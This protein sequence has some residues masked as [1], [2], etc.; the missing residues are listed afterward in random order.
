MLVYICVC[1]YVW[2]VLMF[3]W[4]DDNDKPFL[5]KTP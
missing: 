1:V 4:Y 5:T 3:E 2:C